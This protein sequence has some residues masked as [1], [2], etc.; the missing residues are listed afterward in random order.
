MWKP[1]LGMILLLVV[2]AYGHAADPAG[3]R[4]PRQDALV[5]A[6][7]TAYTAFEE[8]LPQRAGGTRAFDIFM[9]NIENYRMSI[10]SEDRGFV[11]EFSPKPFQ[12]ELV[13]GGVTRYTIDMTGSEILHVAR[14]R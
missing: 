7:A 12:G 5:K 14:Y 11:V 4:V 8:E 2:V 10:Y 6:C 1:A 13:R 3:E 9:S